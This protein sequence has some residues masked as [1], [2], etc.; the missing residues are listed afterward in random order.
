MIIKWPFFSS[1]KYLPKQVTDQILTPSFRIISVH[2][3]ISA[4]SHVK[5]QDAE[6]SSLPRK[7]CL[8]PFPNHANMFTTWSCQY[9][10]S[11]NKLTL[12]FLLRNCWTSPWISEAMKTIMHLLYSENMSSYCSLFKHYKVGK[13][14]HTANARQLS[15]SSCRK[16]CELISPVSREHQV[17]GIPVKLL[18]IYSLLCPFLVLSR[19]LP[20][21]NKAIGSTGNQSSHKKNHLYLQLS[22]YTNWLQTQ[23]LHLARL[24]SSTKWYRVCCRR[25]KGTTVGVGREDRHWNRLLVIQHKKKSSGSKVLSS[26]RHITILKN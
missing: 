10:T 3:M 14:T 23:T 12:V 15:S 4:W 26:L 1:K 9:A 6:R 17:S 25:F 21:N 11:F 18:K 8:E 19:P 24:Q 2:D 13:L 16:I 5:Q 22:H 20:C 7:Y